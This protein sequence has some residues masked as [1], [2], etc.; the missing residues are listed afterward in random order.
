MSSYGLDDPANLVLKISRSTY[1]YNIIDRAEINKEFGY[2]YFKYINL[3]KK[4]LIGL[5]NIKLLKRTVIRV[6]NDE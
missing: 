3:H 6:K 4:L 5:R 1:I 2:D